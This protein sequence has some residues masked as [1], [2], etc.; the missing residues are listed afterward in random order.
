MSL[1]LHHRLCAWGEW[2]P[3]T[4]RN[5]SIPENRPA[6]FRRMSGSLLVCPRGRTLSFTITG[7]GTSH[8]VYGRRCRLLLSLKVISQTNPHEGL[9]VGGAPMC[10][11]EVTD[12][13]AAVRDAA[14]VLPHRGDG[15]ATNPQSVRFVVP[16]RRFFDVEHCPFFGVSATTT[17]QWR[18]GTSMFQ[19][20]RAG[21]VS[22]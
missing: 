2:R 16:F 17:H 12:D 4:N 9:P 20:H 8:H 10:F 14:A 11:L 5:P 19:H 18:S 3:S 21:E 15:P 1:L 6:H 7:E 13:F 22:R